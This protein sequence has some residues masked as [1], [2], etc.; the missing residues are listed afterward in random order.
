MIETPTPSILTRDDG[1]AIAYH[2]FSANTDAPGVVF[3]SG[4]MS[5]MMGTKAL[6]V[7]A[8]CR[9]QKVSFLR[10][11][12]RGHGQSEGAF[13]DG[14]IGLWAEDAVFAVDQLTKGPQ[15][16]IGSSM[17]GWIMLLVAL[18]LKQRIAGLIG[19]AAA[20]DFTEHLIDNELTDDDR[21]VLERDGFITVPTEYDDEPYVITRDLIEDGRT[22]ML[23]NAAIPL[24]LPVRLIQGLKDDDVPWR[25]AL[26]LQQQLASD[27]VE[28]TLIKDGDHRLSDPTDLDRLTSTLGRL[29]DHI[30]AASPSR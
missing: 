12:Y 6:A 17:G 24:A 29:I 20:P 8:W 28:V 14:T 4:F 10:F 16:L 30:Q 13:R 18:K 11:D 19:I 27:D 9:Q 3:L 5:D 26:H 22:Q 7:E 1:P 25:T 2:Q 21:A 23:L 15:I